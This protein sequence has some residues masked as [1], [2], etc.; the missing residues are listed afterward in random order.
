ME[1]RETFR[2]QNKIAHLKTPRKSTFQNILKV[3]KNGTLQSHF[4]TLKIAIFGRIARIKTF[5]TAPKSP[6]ISNRDPVDRVVKEPGSNLE[7]VGSI[8]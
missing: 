4:S 7:V 6:T 8:P 5:C 2:S 3:K 1:N